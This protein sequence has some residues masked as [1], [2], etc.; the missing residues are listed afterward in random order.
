M[1]INDILKDEKENEVVMR[2]S[3]FSENCTS[4]TKYQGKLV[5][6][7]LVMQSCCCAM[8]YKPKESYAK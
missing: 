3:A 5:K 7:I 6:P 4:R 2:F 8:N 1:A